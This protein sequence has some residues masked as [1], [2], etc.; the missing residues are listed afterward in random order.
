MNDTLAIFDEFGDKIA[1]AVMPEEFDA[2]ATSEEEQRELGAAFARRVCVP[3]KSAFVNLSSAA[4]LTKAFREG[5]YQESR[6][7]YSKELSMI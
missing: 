6:I 7:I 4:M 1:I 2:A 3:G 5:C